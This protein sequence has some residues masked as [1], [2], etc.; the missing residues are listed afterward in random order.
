MQISTLIFFHKQPVF[1]QLALG[2]QIAKKTFRD[3][4]FFH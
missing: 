3:Q 1:K 4:P 2:W